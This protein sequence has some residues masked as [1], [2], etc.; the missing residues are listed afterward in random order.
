M[1]I[2]KNHRNSKTLKMH[3]ALFKELH[4]N[5]KYSYHLLKTSLE[6][7]EKNRNSNKLE[8]TSFCLFLEAF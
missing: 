1:K 2:I 3:E 8:N 7:I 4:K 6:I 5:E